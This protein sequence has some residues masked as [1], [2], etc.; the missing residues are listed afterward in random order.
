MRTVREINVR[1]TSAVAS[2]EDSQESS[3]AIGKR[4]FVDAVLEGS[5]L[6]LNDKVRVTARLIRVGDQTPIWA[7]QFEKTV[8]DELKLQDEIAAGC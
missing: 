7:G 3:T 5:I 4:L 1:P 8:Q 2:F 6:R